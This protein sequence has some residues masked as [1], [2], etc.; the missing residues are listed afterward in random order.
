MPPCAGSCAASRRDRA[1][2][3]ALRSADNAASGVG[4]AGDVNQDELEARIA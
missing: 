4:A 2:L 3:F 1:L